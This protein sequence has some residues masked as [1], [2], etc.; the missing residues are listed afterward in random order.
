M[1]ARK[2]GFGGWFKKISDGSAL[3]CV[4]GAFAPLPSHPCEGRDPSSFKGMPASPE[5]WMGSR[6]RGNDFSKKLINTFK[7]TTYPIPSIIDFF[8]FWFT[9]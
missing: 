9:A 7:S 5:P 4:D 6:L 3:R 2:H 1:D 8:D